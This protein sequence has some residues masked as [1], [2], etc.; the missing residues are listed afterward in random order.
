MAAIKADR[1]P[2]AINRTIRNERDDREDREESTATVV[3]RALA[4]SRM[5]AVANSHPKNLDN[6]KAET[7]TSKAVTTKPVVTERVRFD[8]V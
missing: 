6:H 4:I 8:L 7:E 5:A 3:I 2:K 1:S